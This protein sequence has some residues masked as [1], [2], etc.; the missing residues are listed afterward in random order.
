LDVHKVCDIRQ[1]EA[2]TAEPLVPGPTQLEVEIAISK[3]MKYKSPD[4]DQ[5]PVELIQAAD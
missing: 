3:F 1:I 4:K 2:Y 5:I